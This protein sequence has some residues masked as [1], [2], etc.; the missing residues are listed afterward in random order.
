MASFFDLADKSVNLTVIADSKSFGLAFT[1]RVPG[2]DNTVLTLTKTSDPVVIRRCVPGERLV[3]QQCVNC[4]AGRA[5]WRVFLRVCLFI[6]VFF[7]SGTFG[8][9]S[10]CFSCPAGSP[11]CL[12]GTLILC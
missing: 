12:L 8:N 1:A 9:F 10:G 11:C 7:V 4:L 6:T 2:F 3:S 5:L